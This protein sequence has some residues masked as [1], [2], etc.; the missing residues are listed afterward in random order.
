M[1]KENEIGYATNV[2]F[3]TIVEDGFKTAKEDGCE[4]FEYTVGK[5][6]GGELKVVFE[7]DSG[8]YDSSS[9]DGVDGFGYA[10][11]FEK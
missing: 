11:A 7:P 2:S 8:S 10:L 3:Q 4:G 1:S 9:I 6:K 5:V